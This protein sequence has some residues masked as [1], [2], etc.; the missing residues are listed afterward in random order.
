[1]AD[2]QKA[3]VRYRI[4]TRLVTWDCEDGCC[5]DTWG[6][7]ALL[8][9]STIPPTVLCDHDGDRWASLGTVETL[10]R[11]AAD[12]RGI[13]MSEIEA[14]EVSSRNENERRDWNW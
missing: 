11:E 4:I 13:N 7:G 3:P 5:S 6:E 8:D 9:M 14:I 12:K 2:R 10:L 1:M